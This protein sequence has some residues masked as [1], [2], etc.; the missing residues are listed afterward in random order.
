[1]KES[2]LIKYLNR[3]CSKDEILE[4]EEW[5]ATS[6]DNAEKLF[7]LERIWSIKDE[8]QFSQSHSINRA[9][10][11]FLSNIKSKNCTPEPKSIH[12]KIVWNYMRYAAIILILISVTINI[13]QWRQTY[14]PINSNT[15]EVPSGQSILLTLSDGTRVW[16]NSKSKLSYPSSFG[17][18]NREVCLEGEGYFEVEHNPK[19]PFIV[20]LPDIKIKVLGTKFNARAYHDEVT[21]VTLIEGKVDISESDG[22]NSI[23]LLPNEQAIYSTTLGLYKEYMPESDLSSRWTSGEL[24]FSDQS[25]DEIT[26]TLE[27]HFDVKITL[28][29]T[30]LLTERFTCHTPPKTSLVEI[31]ELLKNTRKVD[32]KVTDREVLLINRE[33]AMK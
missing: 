22:K 24:S 30:T 5:I 12:K 9:Y 28:T 18:E 11:C 13:Y 21:K 29:D 33:E 3:C 2:L 15:I 31:L 7:E 14:L 25:L 17:E 19:I 4:V 10:D 27:R 6:K 32:Y 16:L 8:L 20:K 26:H 1:M 23:I